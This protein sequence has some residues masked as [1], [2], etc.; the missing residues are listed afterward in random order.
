MAGKKILLMMGSPRKEGNS[1][2]L[3]KQLA[4]G[5]EAT[6]AEVES[7]YLHGMNIQP[8]TACDECRKETGKGC[9]IDDEGRSGI[10]ILLDCS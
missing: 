5:A 1:A 9:V 3:A 7:F 10:D 4:A 6:G 8:C 2:T